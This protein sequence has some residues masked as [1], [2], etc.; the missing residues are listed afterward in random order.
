MLTDNQLRRYSG[1]IHNFLKDVSRDGASGEDDVIQVGL[2]DPQLFGEAALGPASLGDDKFNEI[3]VR[4]LH[5][6]L[7]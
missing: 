3:R 2:G 1:E 7:G 5:T 4:Y 6:I